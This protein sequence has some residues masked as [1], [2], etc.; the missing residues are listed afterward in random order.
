M[1]RTLV[2]LLVLVMLTG[3]AG[4]SSYEDLTIDQITPEVVEAFREGMSS[5]FSAWS[6]AQLYLVLMATQ[7]E[8]I[9]RGHSVT[10]PQ[11]VYIVGIDLPA[12]RYTVTL[13][14]PESSAA[15]IINSDSGDGAAYALFDTDAANI[16]V[17]D[18][19]QIEVDVSTVKIAPYMGLGW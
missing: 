3:C 6:D 16:W 11:G 12:G 1:K 15:V 10:V 9:G 14:N 18:G 13:A 17:S 5:S 19:D 4:A 8:Y 2:C 7:M